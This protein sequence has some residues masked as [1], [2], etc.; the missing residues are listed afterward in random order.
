MHFYSE[1][2]VSTSVAKWHLVY[3]LTS[4]EFVHEF[5]ISP[6]A[7]CVIFVIGVLCFVSKADGSVCRLVGM[8]RGRAVRHARAQGGLRQAFGQRLGGVAESQA[9]EQIGG[10]EGD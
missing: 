7:P 1:V 9:R 5:N 4:M 6:F 10:S 2:N 3:L 8:P